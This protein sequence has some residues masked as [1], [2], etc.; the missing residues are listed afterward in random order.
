MLFRYQHVFKISQLMFR[1]LNRVVSHLRPITTSMSS[2]RSASTTSSPVYSEGIPLH[3]LQRNV[4]YA[5]LPPAV[6][7]ECGSFSPITNLHLQLFE[8]NRDYLMKSERALNIIGGIIS[9]VHDAYGK[10][11]LVPYHHRLNMVAAATQDNDWVAVSDWE[12]QQPGWTRTRVVLDH[13]AD[14][15]ERVN[16]G[17]QV[18]KKPLDQQQSS[19]DNHT[20]VKVLLCMGS[21]VLESFMVPGVWAQEDVRISFVF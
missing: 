14:V 9:P 8:M 4:Q 5:D 19:T 15:L 10:K 3:K 20:Q 1:R 12:G 2:I 17:K 11:S 18:Y 6:L 21:D 13:V 7:V 16:V